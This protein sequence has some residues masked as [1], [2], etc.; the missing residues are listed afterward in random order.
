MYELD[1]ARERVAELRRSAAR[2]RDGSPALVRVRQFI[3]RRRRA[4]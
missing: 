3:A 4:Q 1:L 2:T